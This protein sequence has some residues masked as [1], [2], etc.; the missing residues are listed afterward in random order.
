M[1]TRLRTDESGMAI[2]T[3]LLVLMLASGLMAGMYAALL[4]D[5]KS[6]ATDRDQSMAYAAAHA[7]L[8]KLTSNLGALFDTDFSPSAADIGLIDNFPPTIPNFQFVS[9]G[10]GTGSGYQITFP[11][12]PGPG[13]NT[14][15]PQATVGTITTGN[16][17]GLQGLITPYVITVTA[18]STTGNSEVRLRR[19]LQT[20]A[21]P[22][23]QFGIF[24]QTDLGF[25]AG[26]SFNFGGRVHT[27]GSLFLA[28]GNGNTLTLA[29]KVTAWV[30]V[31]RNRIMN[32]ADITTTNHTGTVRVPTVIGSTYRNLGSGESSGTVNTPCVGS[33]TTDSNCWTGWKNL[34][35]VT[36]ATN[37]RTRATGARQLQL[38]IAQAG[39]QP[40]DLIRRP[41]VL[42]A[43][44]T[45]NPV[46]YGQRYFSQ[47]SLRI[48][49]SDRATDITGLPTVSAT[50]PVDLATF[51]NMALG[52]V[53][54]AGNFPTALSQGELTTNGGF[55]GLP[56]RYTRVSAIG[57]STLTMQWSTTG[58]G[59]WTNGV[60][61]WL[62]WTEIRI[63]AGAWA[64][65]G[66]VVTCLGMNG[67]QL[68]GCGA[69]PS[70]AINTEIRISRPDEWPLNVRVSTAA[71]A[72]STTIGM[73]GMPNNSLVN[74]FNATKTFFVAE[75]PV[76]CTAFDAAGNNLLNCGWGGGSISANDPAYLGPTVNHD[77]PYLHGF[78]KIEMQNN[79]GAWSDVT[80][81]LLNLGFTGPNQ[82]GQPCADPAPNAVIRLQRLRDNGLLTA[83]TLAANDYSGLFSNPHDL[84]PNT[85]FDAREGSTR[86]LGTGDG[87]HTGGIFSYVAL[88]VNNYRRW[89]NGEIGATGT[90]SLNNNGFIVYFSDRRG[91][92]DT[93]L[94]NNPETGEYGF[95]DSLNPT[96]AAWNRDLILNDGEDVNQNGT[97]ERYGELP[98]SNGVI[99]NYIGAGAVA[100]FDSSALSSPWSQLALNQA[101]RGR[102]ARVTLFRRALKIINGGMVGATNNIPAA[103]FTVAS[104]N[105]V[106]V[107]GNFN[108]TTTSVTAEPNVATSIVADAITLLSNSFVDGS[109]FRWP[110]NQTNRNAT[111]TSYRFAMITGKA[112]PF[113]HP[114]WG[115]TEWGSDGGVHNFM[116]MIEDWG[117]Q[118]LG[119]R[120]SMVSLF[121]SRQATGPYRADANVYS[122]PSRGYNFDTDFLTPALLPPGTPAFRDINTLKF[123]QILRPNQ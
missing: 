87:P 45:T 79:A 12:D 76:T 15:N 67:T 75:N 64:G 70:F 41:A 37:I 86:L 94:V 11:V 112:L 101:G 117:G 5:Q 20:V 55:A 4:A 93:T 52:Y 14:G 10:G 119:Y 120:G 90:Q 21:V 25:H 30:Q 44:D 27:N 102:L 54:S 85:I 78:L 48:L 88:D 38:P 123:R 43:E 74:Q 49:L 56:T 46:V 100:P 72:N 32:G 66:T 22:V 62:K 115:V 96:A 51:R 53:P 34:S 33:A 17:E 91:N 111:Q 23:F 103:G 68:L 104:E 110:N 16:W 106:F 59:G 18:R 121:F 107:H 40:I 36:Y 7:G 80:T 108:A 89:L 58:T 28:Q 97:L 113:Q 82:D 84:W 92:H 29:D 61:D 1:R 95:E 98:T 2:I 105:P 31:V 26:P 57:G 50:P 6:H 73:N 69:H 81:E 13:P 122:P 65:G 63:G 35:E 60:P 83:C 114:G 3:S 116:R 118:S 42:S 77:T 47:A 39:A 24:G 19:E 9:P 109:T 8:E 71:A 99:P